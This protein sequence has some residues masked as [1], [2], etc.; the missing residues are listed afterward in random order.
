MKPHPSIL[1]FTWLAGLGQGLL[2]ALAALEFTRGDVLAASARDLAGAVALGVALLAAGLV[3]S[4]FHLGRPSRGWRAA[5]Q[6]RT[7]WLSREVIVLPALMAATT[8]HAALLWM[9]EDVSAPAVRATAAACVGLALALWWC[10]GMIYAGLR[11]VQAWAT[12]LTPLVFAALGAAGGTLLAGAWCARVAVTGDGFEDGGSEVVALLAVAAAALVVVASVLKALWW[13]R[14]R[15]LMPR[16]TLQSA[17]AIPRPQIRQLAMGMTGGSFNTREFFHGRSPA[18]VHVMAAAMVLFAGAVPLL[19][20]V[21]GWQ[22]AVHGE[23]DAAAL[24]L[25]GAVVAHSLGVLA[26]RWLFFAWAQHP[27]NLYYQ[28]VS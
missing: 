27:Q 28:R 2:L 25:G 26:E 22:Q 15:T 19:L 14:L 10:T 7:S 21:I 20:A 13:Q 5:S 18:V 9:T 6:W 16:S 24:T 17:L 11:M 3:A 12:P 1:F 8:L 4:V 23:V